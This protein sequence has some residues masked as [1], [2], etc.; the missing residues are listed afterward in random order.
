MGSCLVCGTSI[1]IGRLCRSHASAAATCDAITAEQIIATE[2][3]TPRGWL[4]DQWGC[5]HPIGDTT[6]IGRSVADAALA[7]LHPSVSVVHA[8]VEYGGRG[9][10]VID[11][12]SL[13][14][15][16][17]HGE[18][19]RVAD[20]AGGALLRFGEVSLFFSAGT[21]PQVQEEPTTGRTQPSRLSDLSVN[22]TLRRAGVECE[23]LQRPGGG[24]VRI[25][26]DTV[27]ELARLEFGL[28]AL[29][30]ERAARADDPDLAFLSSAELSDRLEFNSS[31]A[32]SDNVRELVR[33]VRK[34]LSAAGVDQLIDSRQRVGYRVSWDIRLH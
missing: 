16:F 23:L 2:P 5:T 20:L 4:I 26:G 9:W 3:E 19:V 33:R 21:V 28:L 7:I 30:V 13:N 10:R 15:T 31:H 8:H 1:R 14:G 34:K 29:L 17:V 11:R 6:I 25:A 18:R 22:A 27:L 32:D 12:G 24:I